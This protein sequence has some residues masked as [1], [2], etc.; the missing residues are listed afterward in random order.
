MDYSLVTTTEYLLKY[1]AA[2]HEVINFFIFS[3]DEVS[4]VLGVACS[5]LFKLLIKFLQ[6][7]RILFNN[8][9]LQKLIK[10]LLRQKFVSILFTQMRVVI[11]FLITKY[12]EYFLMVQLIPELNLGHKKYLFLFKI[13][14]VSFLISKGYLQIVLK[15]AKVNEFFNEK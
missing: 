2:N 7:R 8:H 9:K 15:S 13:F 14:S 5:L 4:L 10:D 12:C 3:W 6:I 1:E 11:L